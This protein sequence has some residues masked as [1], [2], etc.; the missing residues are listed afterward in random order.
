MTHVNP[1]DIKVRPI[2]EETAIKT[3]KA[4]TFDIT[5]AD[6]IFDQLLLAKIIKLLP[7]HNIPKAEELK[8][9]TY[10]KYHNS[11]K[12]TTNNCVVFR[13]AIQSWIDSG[14]LKFPEKKMGVDTDPFPTTTVGMVDAHFPKDKGKGKIELVS[15]RHITKKNSQPWLKIDLFSNAPP[16]RNNRTSGRRIHVKF[17]GRVRFSSACPKKELPATAQN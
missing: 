8:G 2:F 17:K 16:K 11:N 10:C 9:M 6:A 12:H 4:Y 13:D 3:S 14:K 5:K 7:G 15:A 1:K